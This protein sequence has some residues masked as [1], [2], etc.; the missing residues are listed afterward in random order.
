MLEFEHLVQ[1][2]DLNNDS[3]AD[4]TREQLWQGLVLRARSPHKFNQGLRCQSEQVVGNQFMRVIEAGDSLFREKVILTPQQSI[5]TRTVSN[6]EQLQAESITRI[7]EPQA[8][9][10][11]VRF[12]YRRDLPAPSEQVDIAE[13]LKSA[14]VQLDRDAVAM[15]RM[16]AESRLFDEP[17]N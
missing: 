5:H 16:L 10:L 14:W 2:N 7:E 4:I 8:G 11:F 13:H 1:V 17:V 9:Y 3:I 12:N 15:I 6:K